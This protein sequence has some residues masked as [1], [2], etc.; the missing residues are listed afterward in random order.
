MYKYRYTCT[1]AHKPGQLKEP[2]YSP[3]KDRKKI[4]L[5]EETK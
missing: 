2:M 3:M 4:L 5:R 1:V